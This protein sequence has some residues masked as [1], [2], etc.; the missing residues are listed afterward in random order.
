MTRHRSTGRP[1]VAPVLCLAVLLFQ[2]TLASQAKT[3][4]DLRPIIDRYKQETGAE[5]RLDLAYEAL[6]KYA[7]VPQKSVL[8]PPDRTV[9][10]D[11][12]R[13]AIFDALGG[14]NYVALVGG[15]GSTGNWLMKTRMKDDYTGPEVPRLK[16]QGYYMEGLSDLDFAVMGAAAYAFTG[17]LY[18]VFARGRGDTQL[19]RGELD[20]LEISF[21]S[22][23]QITDVS[24]GGDGLK[25]WKQMMD[26]SRSSYHPEK[27]LTK[28]GKALYCV[29]HLQMRGAAVE[30]ARAM[31]FRDWTRA[32]AQTIPPFT[33]QYLYGGSCDMDYFARHALEKTDQEKLKTVL[34]VAKYLKRQAWMLDQTVQNVGRLPDGLVIDP[35]R[36][37]QFVDRAKLLNALCDAAVDD[38][39]WKG[40]AFS[41]FRRAALEQAS[42]VCLGGHNLARDMGW[43]LV[44]KAERNELTQAQG[45]V[46]EE[47]A[48]DLRTVHEQRYRDRKPGWY[49]V[50]VKTDT[51]ALLEAI[52]QVKPRLDVVLADARSRMPADPELAEAE[53]GPLA[54]PPVAAL[55]LGDPTMTP[56]R[57][58]AGAKV[59]FSVQGKLQGLLEGPDT[60]PPAI[61]PDQLKA[62]QELSFWSWRAARARMQIQHLLLT[63]RKNALMRE[64]KERVY[65]SP[66]EIRELA[67]ELKECEESVALWSDSL[68]AKAPT[69]QTGRYRP[70]LRPAATL[71][72][73]EDYLKALQDT[74]EQA[75]TALDDLHAKGERL[76]KLAEKVSKDPRAQEA[77]V[78]QQLA[79]ARKRL[80]A[81][82]KQSKPQ[83]ERTKALLGQ[84]TKYTGYAGDVKKAFSGDIG[85]LTQKAGE[86][87]E[88]LFSLAD[89]AQT[90]AME[91]QK[92]QN[93]LSD[94]IGLFR[95]C[96][97]SVPGGDRFGLRKELVGQVRV[98]D[99]EKNELMLNKIP[100]LQERAQWLNRG[101]WAAK[102]VRVALKTLNIVQ[103]YRA[104]RAALD[105]SLRMTGETKTAVM[106]LKACGDII[107]AGA[108]YIPIP[109]LR[110]TIKDYASLLSSANEWSLAF[111]KMLDQQRQGL[112]FDVFPAP[113]A[114]KALIK[115]SGRSDPAYFHR[116]EGNF[117][118]TNDL[119]VIAYTTRPADEEGEAW[120]IWA[121][122]REDG[123]L[124]L[125]DKGAADHSFKQA[126]LLA[127]RYR[128]LYKRPITVE[129]MKDLLTT[130][131]T[132]RGVFLRETIKAKQVTDRGKWALYTEAAAEYIASTVSRRQF[133]PEELARYRGMMALAAE[134]IGKAGF[135]VRD[136][137][138]RKILEP[139]KLQPTL[140]GWWDAVFSVVN[141]A[142]EA[143][144]WLN[145]GEKQRVQQGTEQVIRGK[146]QA[147][148]RARQ[149]LWAHAKL[150]S[151]AAGLHVKDIRVRVEHALV[152]PGETLEHTMTV[153]PD[154]LN[155][156]AEWST[157]LP[158]KLK[159]SPVYLCKA[160]IVGA[161]AA[162]DECELPIS[163]PAGDWIIIKTGNNTIRVGR[164]ADLERTWVSREVL[165]A[166][167]SDDPIKAEQLEGT[168]EYGTMGE[169]LD[170]IIDA[171]D[172]G[173]PMGTKQI[174]WRWF[175]QN[176]PKRVAMA[177]IK[178]QDYILHAFADKVM[179]ATETR[180]VQFGRIWYFPAEEEK[181][182]WD[183]GVKPYVPLENVYLLH[184]TGQGTRNGYQK[185]D[186][187]KLMSER[188]NAE[189][190]V[191]IPD[192]YWLG[193]VYITDVDQTIGPFSDSHSVSLALAA[194]SRGDKRVTVTA[195]GTGLTITP[196]SAPEP[197]ED[198]PP[199]A[200]LGLLAEAMV[201]KGPIRIAQ[202]KDQ[203]KF[204]NFPPG[205][206]NELLHGDNKFGPADYQS[207][208]KGYFTG[209]A[210][211]S[212]EGKRALMK[213]LAVKSIMSATGSQPGVVLYPKGRD[214]RTEGRVFDG[215]TVQGGEPVASQKWLK[216]NGEAVD[217]AA[218]GAEPPVRVAVRGPVVPSLPGGVGWDTSGNM[219]GGGGVRL[220]LSSSGGENRYYLAAPSPTR[221]TLTATSPG[222]FQVL[223]RVGEGRLL[224][225]PDVNCQRGATYTLNLR[226]DGA[227]D[228]AGPGVRLAGKLYDLASA[229]RNEQ[230]LLKQ[231]GKFEQMNRGKYGTKE[232]RV[233]VDKPGTLKVT[234]TTPGPINFGQSG[235]AC[236][237]D[238]I[239]LVQGD[240]RTA[241]RR[242]L[243][244]GDWKK[245]PVVTLTSATVQQPG[246]YIVRV[247]QAVRLSPTWGDV[248]SAPAHD[249]DVIVS[250]E[251]L[252]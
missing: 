129:E 68:G 42:Q 207:R 58:T 107:A 69:S 211:S 167:L 200:A 157:E 119:M 134:R 131:Q 191:K 36:V 22:D 213:P 19:T 64:P 109:V 1:G 174:F 164:T 183:R 187:W 209:L 13:L 78:G 53:I 95:R 83:V 252:Q 63:E 121:P 161:E 215:W 16:Y 108:D 59:T 102:S 31:W 143:W 76:S 47:I 127:A 145:D 130:G 28:G 24:P 27:Y 52:D 79:A 7:Y 8:D 185:L 171:A 151:P 112:G 97:A 247:V 54:P 233:S 184:L 166:G 9:M 178:G 141:P 110:Q 66:Y 124:H 93:A 225:Y 30:K 25:F 41:V 228:L 51:V 4:A 149:R 251:S 155:F 219:R 20:K 190:K 150:T 179:L 163:A 193:S 186:S 222:R 77:G 45:L 203:V 85:L 142:A 80:D 105:K 176:N 246:T 35:K 32:A 89:E 231:R 230:V 188:P 195:P 162:Y 55:Q 86:L 122:D 212:D 103:E 196:E 44:W 227:S 21:L 73:P 26:L 115:S 132:V 216:D 138:V 159:G 221:M 198:N 96:S 172:P 88:Y 237:C 208:L 218:R 235:T 94:G 15:I 182:L 232:Y 3:P 57:V 70:N 111:A 140:T 99:S 148:A 158:E 101:A 154:G 243:S 12:K 226:A 248:I 156:R 48:Y 5:R 177:R 194:L 123:Y 40:P 116:D 239:E 6:D 180:G 90:S 146:E 173:G 74:C 29:E 240:K 152:G 49:D 223:V 229:T 71:A 11:M 18:R 87:E 168:D 23:E 137:D 100:Q 60:G 34:Q 133:T 43:D 236:R 242:S 106:A 238:R 104:T 181:W 204:R 210:S 37:A 147:R 202:E 72:A 33:A 189:G 244:G 120:L 61:T 92:L 135:L 39:V 75:T 160:R 126:S 114:I 113:A 224:D 65:V 98:W 84:V 14:N 67:Q 175:P 220:A 206:V 234:V 118:K 214:W 241:M 144:D 192:P 81:M 250:L 217:G 199:I 91:A 17:E 50:V 201:E 245:S 125:S 62:M 165:W 117:A 56:S 197:S 139:V 82:L 169:A 38:E 136:D 249:Y 10:S 2:L 170:A 128:R 46:L 205:Y 153:R